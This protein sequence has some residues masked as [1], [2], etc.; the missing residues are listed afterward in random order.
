MNSE[1]VYENDGDIYKAT[2]KLTFTEEEK[3]KIGQ[4]AHTPVGDARA[5]ILHKAEEQ[6]CGHREQDYGSPENNFAFIAKLWT[7]WL[8]FPVTAFDVAMMMCLLKIARI[9]QGGGS[10]DSFVDLCGYGACAGEIRRNE[11]DGK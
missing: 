2:T 10:G 6:I 8:D 4:I 5:E 7:D 1:T 3:M 11:R 9:R